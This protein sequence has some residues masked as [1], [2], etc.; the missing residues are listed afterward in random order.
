MLRDSHLSLCQPGLSG[1]WCLKSA[2]GVENIKAEEEQ[3]PSELQQ[4]LQ[5]QQHRQRFWAEK[6]LNI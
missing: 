4:Q 3:T 2:A 1:E 6:V 5:Q